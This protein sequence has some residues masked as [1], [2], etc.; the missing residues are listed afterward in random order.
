[1]TYSEAQFSKGHV[2]SNVAC[3]RP[4]CQAERGTWSCR[5]ELDY[6][7]FFGVVVPQSRIQLLICV[8]IDAGRN[9]SQI[10]G[11]RVENLLIFRCSFT[12]M[13]HICETLLL[14]GWFNDFRH[15][16]VM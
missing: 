6:T 15:P 12:L 14:G 5:Y 1:M 7:S 10:E 2:H 11:V 16:G 3:L 4:T 9:V 13:P 8:G